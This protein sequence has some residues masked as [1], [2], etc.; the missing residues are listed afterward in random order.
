M[1]ED[2]ISGYLYNELFIEINEEKCLAFQC[3]PWSL[4]A[5]KNTIRNC[6]TTLQAFSSRSISLYPLFPL[7]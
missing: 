7:S 4:I 3:M 1:I 6:S 2:R 5:H